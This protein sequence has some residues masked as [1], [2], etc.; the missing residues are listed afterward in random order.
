MFEKKMLAVFKNSS[1]GLRGGFGVA[2]KTEML[3][4]TPFKSIN[5]SCTKGIYTQGNEHNNLQAIIP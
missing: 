1:F 4:I 5:E 2:F 3:E